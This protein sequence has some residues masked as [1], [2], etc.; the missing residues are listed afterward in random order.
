MQII[1]G[2]WYL[3][4]LFKSYNYVK[5]FKNKINFILIEIKI[6]NKFIFLYKM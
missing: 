3:Y 1:I 2:I 4:A 5:I 6:K